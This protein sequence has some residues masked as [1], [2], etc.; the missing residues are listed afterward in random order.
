MSLTNS[1]PRAEPDSRARRMW[2]DENGAGAGNPWLPSIQTVAAAPVVQDM[3]RLD[4]V[5]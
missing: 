2:P 3:V 5:C 1:V 4:A